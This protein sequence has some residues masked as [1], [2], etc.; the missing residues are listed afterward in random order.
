MRLINA[1]AFMEY[2][3]LEDTEESREENY[4]EI[5]TLEDFDRQETAYDLDK[6]IE[7]LK[8]CIYRIDDSATLSTRDVINE[9]DVFEIVKRGGIE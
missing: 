3:G 1:D 6:V 2:I 9:E 8:R 5:V 4:G 7:Q